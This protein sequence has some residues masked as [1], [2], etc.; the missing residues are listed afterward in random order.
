[1]LISKVISTEQ[2]HVAQ[3]MGLAYDVLCHTGQWVDFTWDKL[4][5]KVHYVSGPY[6]P[7]VNH[8]CISAVN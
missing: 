2:F 8:F 4:C 3:F 1:M 5:Y 6:N 7:L